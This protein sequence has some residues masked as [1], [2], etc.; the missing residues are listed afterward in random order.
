MKMADDLAVTRDQYRPPSPTIRAVSGESRNEAA[1][2]NDMFDLDE[3]WEPPEWHARANC[4]GVDPALFFPERG[5]QTAE[6]KEVCTGCV[7][8]AECLEQGLTEKHGIWGGKSERERR[9]L[10]RET[11]GIPVVLKGCGTRAAYMRG[12]SCD[13]CRAANALYHRR[14]G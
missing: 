3:T 7:V 4:L 8:K 1:A 6:A 2:T 11:G 10:R 12:C 9:K 14:H 5:E 13:A